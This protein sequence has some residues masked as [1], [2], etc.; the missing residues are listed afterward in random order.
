MEN[1]EG[2]P[3][4]DDHFFMLVN[5]ARVS[6]VYS[7]ETSIGLY[8]WSHPN[9]ITFLQTSNPFFDPKI[10]KS[11]KIIH[12]YLAKSNSIVPRVVYKDKYDVEYNLTTLDEISTH[13]SRGSPLLET[14][15]C[16]KAKTTSQDN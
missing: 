7:D 15:S 14:L 1:I 13:T 10:L 6:K 2:L 3:Q 5:L 16:T 12:I 9:G 11:E 4:V 8:Q